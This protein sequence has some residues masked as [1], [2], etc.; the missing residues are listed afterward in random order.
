MIKQCL[1]K[2]NKY[3]F[4]YFF[5]LRAFGDSFIIQHSNIYKNQVKFGNFENRLKNQIVKRFFFNFIVFCNVLLFTTFTKIYVLLTRNRFNIKLII[6]LI[7]K[8]L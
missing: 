4:Q 5:L 6:K 2:K 3:T 7:K 1:F 8:H